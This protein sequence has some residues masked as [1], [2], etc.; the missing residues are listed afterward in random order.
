MPSVELQSGLASLVLEPV[1]KAQN[2]AVDASST[3]LA[4]LSALE[5]EALAH[6]KDEDGC[7]DSLPSSF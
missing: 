4:W 2:L 3:T 5:A 7:F 1:E 6:E